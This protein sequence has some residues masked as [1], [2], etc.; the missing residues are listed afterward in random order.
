MQIA[1]T[2]CIYSLYST[3]LSNIMYLFPYKSLNAFE[4]ILNKYT[5]VNLFLRLTKSK[6]FYRHSFFKQ[7]PQ[8][9]EQP[10]S[11]ITKY[12]NLWTT[13]IPPML[14]IPGKTWL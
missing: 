13:S 14:L 8:E 9:H 11:Q 4:N 7:L 10:V 1:P 6:A 5:Y 3:S 2:M 12:L